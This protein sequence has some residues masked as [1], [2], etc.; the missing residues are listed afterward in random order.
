MYIRMYTAA[1]P[2]PSGRLK[3]ISNMKGYEGQAQSKW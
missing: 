1:L 3:E 2:P